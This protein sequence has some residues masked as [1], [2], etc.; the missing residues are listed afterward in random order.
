MHVGCREL[1]VGERYCFSK[2]KNR[3][4]RLHTYAYMHLT[5]LSRWKAYFAYLCRNMQ[6]AHFAYLRDIE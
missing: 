1:F 5:A 3:C 2:K 6:N 4:I